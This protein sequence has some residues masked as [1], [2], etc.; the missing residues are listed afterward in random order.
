MGHC[1]DG[2]GRLICDVC[3]QPGAQTRYNHGDQC[4]ACFKAPRIDAGPVTSVLF[5]GTDG[6]SSQYVVARCRLIWIR[7]HA[8]VMYLEAIGDLSTR[9][10]VMQFAENEEQRIATLWATPDAPACH[11]TKARGVPATVAA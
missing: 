4:A 11:V 3:G 9:L 10:G 1:Y 5:Q 7:G 2:R 6:R 8:V